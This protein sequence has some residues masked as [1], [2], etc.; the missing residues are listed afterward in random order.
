MKNDSLECFLT[1]ADNNA[2]GYFAKQGFTKEITF[3]GDRVRLPCALC[4]RL[5]LLCWSP[6]MEL[7]SGVWPGHAQ[8][9]AT[10]P[11][12]NLRQCSRQSSLF[13]GCSHVWLGTCL[14]LLA[15]SLCRLRLSACSPRAS[16]RCSGFVMWSC[17]KQFQILRLCTP[18][19]PRTGKPAL[20]S[21][22]NRA[23]HRRS[24]RATSRTMTAGRSWSACWTTVSRTSTSPR[25]GLTH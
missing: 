16:L 21:M 3:S 18:R 19:D 13:A 14:P 12:C 2:V 25:Q 9:T 5:L 6:S 8:D 20:Y 24:G 7:S 10:R 15:K 11:C 1:Y 4:A 22:P 17:A 23:L